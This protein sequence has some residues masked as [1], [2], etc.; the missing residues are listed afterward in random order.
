MLFTFPSRYW[1]TIGLSVVFSL[2]GWSPQIQTGFHVSR[3]T[4]DTTI[5]Y[6]L[7]CKG[8]SPSTA[9]LSR[10]FHLGSIQ[11]AWSYNPKIAWTTLVWA[12][13][14]SIATTPGIT[15]V[16]FS[17][18]YLDVSVQRVGLLH[19]RISIARWVVPFGYP[20]ID[21]YLPI[22]AAFRSLSRPSS[23]LRA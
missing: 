6:L 11:I 2:A 14:V 20:R 4:Q 10:R 7:P 17:S 5:S 22:P 9:R 3:P 15:I 19:R 1:S 21:S 13:P 18:A 12:P 23:P 16:F 8:L